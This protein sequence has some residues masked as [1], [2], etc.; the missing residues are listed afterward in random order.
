[1]STHGKMIV[2]DPGLHVGQG[3]R[4][5]LQQEDQYETRIASGRGEGGWCHGRED[6][7]WEVG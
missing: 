2:V 1:M 6:G 7:P 4:H 3:W 5:G